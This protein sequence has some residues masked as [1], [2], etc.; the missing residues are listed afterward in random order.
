MVQTNKI[1]IFLTKLVTLI[2]V[3]HREQLFS[4]NTFVY[5]SNLEKKLKIENN[6][7]MNHF[8]LSV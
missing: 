5:R 4:R 3:F 2:S 8:K 6:K 1:R 7:G